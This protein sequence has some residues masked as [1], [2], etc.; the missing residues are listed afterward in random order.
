MTPELQA[1]EYSL[2]Q[3]L[4]LLGNNCLSLF[5]LVAN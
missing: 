4:Q 2:Y 5:G 1:E 3:N